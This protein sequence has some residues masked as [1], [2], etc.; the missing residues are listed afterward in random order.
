MEPDTCAGTT[1]DPGREWD[2]QAVTHENARCLRFACHNVSPR[3]I[4]SPQLWFLATHR[5]SIIRWR[6]F[7]GSSTNYDRKPVGNDRNPC[8]FALR[9]ICALQRFIKGLGEFHVHAGQEFRLDQ[10]RHN[11]H[12]MLIK[13]AGELSEIPTGRRSYGCDRFW[14]LD[15]ESL[16]AFSIRPSS[17]RNQLPRFRPPVQRP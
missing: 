7:T 5:R 12:P 6:A 11:D 13:D 15:R 17:C 8:I 10:I 14:R 3:L 9:L 2:W 4:D 16:S 1:A